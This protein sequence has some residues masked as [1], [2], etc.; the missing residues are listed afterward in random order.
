MRLAWRL[1]TRVVS[2]AFELGDLL[3][4]VLTGYGETDVAMLK[5]SENNWKRRFAS[6]KQMYPESTLEDSVAIGQA[7]GKK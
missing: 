7:L 5:R 2:T 4:M 1:P 3:P 6:Y